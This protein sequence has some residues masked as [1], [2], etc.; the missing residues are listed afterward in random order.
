MVCVAVVLVL[1]SV[2]VLASARRAQVAESTTVALSGLLSRQLALVVN[3]SI[4]DPPQLLSA[5][6][7][8]AAT[9]LSL[10][11]S[12]G[13]P[14]TLCARHTNVFSSSSS[15]SLAV[16]AC[17]P[18]VECT[19]CGGRGGRQCM[20]TDP[21]RSVGVA[22][23]SGAYYTETWG[24]AGAGP[25][26]QGMR[27]GCAAV[28]SPRLVGDCAAGAAASA[29]GVLGLAPSAAGS[30]IYAMP[31]PP[32]F[33]L[34]WDPDGTGGVMTIGSD[35]G[36][37]AMSSNSHMIT[38]AITP[39][40]FWMETILLSVAVTSPTAVAQSAVVIHVNDS[41]PAAWQGA[42]ARTTIASAIAAAA[43][44]P[45]A[46][47]AAIA[48]AVAAV[49]GGGSVCGA[50]ALPL[51]VGSPGLPVPSSPLPAGESLCVLL[52]S[53][54]S[55]AEQL[56]TLPALSLTLVNGVPAG[57]AFDLTAAGT[58]QPPLDMSWKPP[59][60]RTPRCLAIYT[61]DSPAAPL[62]RGISLVGAGS[63]L[64]YTVAFDLNAG[65]V[66][67]RAVPSTGSCAAA[68]ANP[69]P[70]TLP[71]QASA[72]LGATALPTASEAALDAGGGQS[73]DSLSMLW[74]TSAAGILS[75]FAIGALC[76][77][78]CAAACVC[79]RFGCRCSACARATRSY[80]GLHAA[81]AGDDDS[82]WSGD[83]LEHD[84]VVNF[85][86]EEGD[87]MALESSAH[88][89]VGERRRRATGKSARGG[90]TRRSSEAARTRS[91][92]ASSALGRVP[93]QQAR[94]IHFPAYEHGVQRLSSDGV[95][96]RSIA[97]GN[98]F[99]DDDDNFD[100]ADDDAIDDDNI[101]DFGDR[102]ARW[103]DESFSDDGDTAALVTTQAD[104]PDATVTPVDDY[105]VAAA[106]MLA[107]HAGRVARRMA[108]PDAV[109]LADNGVLFAEHRSHAT[110]PL[111]GTF[112][113]RPGTSL[114]AMATAARNGGLLDDIA[115]EETVTAEEEEKEEE[116]YTV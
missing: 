104:A 61:S 17:L 18:T 114:L 14:A 99:I 21:T 98:S 9:G 88:A 68:T 76:C 91:A 41:D 84:D 19:T 7:D 71:R 59:A 25:P 106:S 92:D 38:L 5:I 65:T 26:S 74:W 1:Q 66:T 80:I 54:L 103:D 24:V 29:D 8:T 85:D 12:P 81:G 69:L 52:D 45:A 82:T 72:T 27:F 90:R 86:P 43:Y 79:A 108:V 4:G 15:S 102:Q 39:Q 34:C 77:C 16:V 46:S 93:P 113:S 3:I 64:G 94:V 48:T 6:V 42:G 32:V 20:Y 37:N 83:D 44:L 40:T 75:A 60:G 89:Q 111:G 55:V 70:S 57:A 96:V 62:G 67:W 107:A 58:W 112:S 2:A 22:V 23:A 63:M 97:V 95:P 10:P 116:D 50:A 31:V 109:T 13:S 11:C 53:T 47:A 36:A 110:G 101:D 73:I 115:E 100:D 78:L 87:A 49:C 30:I 35:G 56:A 33:A 28:D 51:L 105:D